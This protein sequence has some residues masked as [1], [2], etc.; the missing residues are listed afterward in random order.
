MSTYSSETVMYTPLPVRYAIYVPCES[1]RR[2]EYTHAAPRETRHIYVVLNGVSAAGNVTETSDS[3]PVE[4][5]DCHPAV[6]VPA[7]WVTPLL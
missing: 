7:I 1:H 3:Q 6:W 2:G 4:G 5:V